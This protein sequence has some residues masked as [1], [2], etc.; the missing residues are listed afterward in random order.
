MLDKNGAEFNELL[1]EK[2][3]TRNFHAE[4]QS[5]FYY[6]NILT[7][8]EQGRTHPY[9]GCSRN[10]CA[11]CY[12]SLCSHGKFSSRG[13]HGSI[14]HRWDI[15]ESTLASSSFCA[16]DRRLLQSVLVCFMEILKS[17]L[18]QLLGSSYPVD[19]RELRAQSSKALSSAKLLAEEQARE[20][21]SS[22]RDIP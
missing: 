22:P 15:P 17:I 20:M 16:G 19:H 11:L 9:I 4:L 3:K 12:L 13:M 5:L 7:P 8:E 6:D 1:D 2:R 14:L 21:E 10:N 18:R